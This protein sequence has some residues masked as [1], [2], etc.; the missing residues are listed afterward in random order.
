M[1]RVEESVLIINPAVAIKLC[2][3][4]VKS[5]ASTVAFA[6]FRRMGRPDFLLRTFED[7]AVTTTLLPWGVSVAS[8]G[9]SVVGL[10][11]C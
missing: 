7:W 11:R 2:Y 8:A 10:S 6:H 1:T 9:K 4:E 5:R 3:M